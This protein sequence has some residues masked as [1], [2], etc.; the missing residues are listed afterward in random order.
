M[1]GGLGQNVTAGYQSQGNSDGG[2]ARMSNANTYKY[3]GPNASGM[4]NIRKV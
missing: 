4:N 1:S 2:S 3:N